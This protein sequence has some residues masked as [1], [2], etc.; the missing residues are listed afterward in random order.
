[1]FHFFN[2]VATPE[3]KRWWVV[4]LLFVAVVVN[5]LDRGNISIAALPLTQELGATPA[6]MGTLLSSFFWTYALLQIPA[7]YIVDRFSLRW[8]YALAFVAWSLASAA[9]GWASTFQQI[10][11]LRLLMGAGSSLDHPLS[12][13]YL[14]QAFREHERGLPT[15]IY[16]S[17]MMV[18]PALGAFVGGLMLEHLGWRQ[19][20]I[21]TGLVPCIWVVPW[22]LLA[23]PARG[24]PGTRSRAFQLSWRQIVSSRLFWGITFGVFFY[25]YF[26]CFFVTWIPS[27]MVM[28]HGLSYSRM[29]SYTAAALLGMAVM[30][31]LGGRLA[32]RWIA[33]LQ[34]P[35]AIRKAFVCTGCLLGSSVLLLLKVKSVPWV[36]ATLVFSLTGFGLASSN[37]WS[38]TQSISP[39]AV[40]GR[41]VGYLNTVGNLA[42]ICA[43]LLTGILM[44]RSKNFQSSIFL[45]GLSL[46]IAVAAIFFLVRAIDVQA[47]HAWF[48]DG[49]QATQPTIS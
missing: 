3:R 5:C 12:V 9:C 30:T 27:Y 29:G 45:A 42:G 14:R 1:M 13:T 28:T 19:L 21:I 23:P 49:P 15:G 46:W 44:G 37:F 47:V 4:S 7:G 25:S 40:V 35:L 43:P 26:W 16:V 34:R 18:G 22:L 17:G 38:L 31:T 39:E 24:A 48:R 11:V 2:G 41:I 32:D 10:I 8:I 36:V 33:L 6:A 20:F